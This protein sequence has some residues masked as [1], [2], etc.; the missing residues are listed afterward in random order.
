MA[1]TLPCFWIYKKVGDH[2]L[3]NQKA[4]DNPYQRWI[5][6]YGGDEF[7]TAVQRAIDICDNAVENTTSDIRNRMTEAFITSTRMEYDFWEAA[8]ELKVWK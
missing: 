8:Y 5:D 3:D 2:I 4:G 1:A 6:T 7:A